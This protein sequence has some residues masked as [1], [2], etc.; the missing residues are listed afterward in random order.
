ML[1]TCDPGS[2]VKGEDPEVPANQCLELFRWHVPDDWRSPVPLLYNATV[3]MI[4]KPHARKTTI[5]K[6][7]LGT[8]GWKEARVKWAHDSLEDGNLRLVKKKCNYTATIVF[9]ASKLASEEHSELTELRK[10]CNA[11]GLQT[12][13]GRRLKCLLKGEYQ[14][15]VCR[16]PL[17]DSDGESK[18][19]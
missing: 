3:P 13:A 19:E 2:E 15:E 8:G 7:D 17:D 6:L 12:T 5:V 1:V 9:T 4:R 14:Q 16:Y 11:D 10:I 18:S